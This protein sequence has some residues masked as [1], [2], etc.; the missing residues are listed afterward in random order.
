M[1][2]ATIA[3]C[4]AMV[5]SPANAKT[6]RYDPGGD[7]VERVYTIERLVASQE[8]IRIVGMCASSCTMFLDER[9]NTCAAPTARFGFHGASP[10]KRGR[11]FARAHG[12]DV[13]YAWHRLMAYHMPD[14]IA[15]QFLTNWIGK[16]GLFGKSVTWKTGVEL[17]AIDPSVRLCDG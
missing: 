7:V 13:E 15:R 5:V 11:D 3:L 4:V 6:V 12:R 8:H 9:L 1:K 14:K 17:N 2:I 16:P 10:D